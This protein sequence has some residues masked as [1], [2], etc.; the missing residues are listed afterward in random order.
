MIP[1]LEFQQR[2]LTGPVMKVDEF[3]LAL[4]KT[5]RR[6]VPKYGIKYNPEELVVD[7]Q[8][9]DAVFQAGVEMLVD[10]GLYNLDTQRVIKFTHEELEEI[11][12]EYRANPARRT[13]G[14]GKDEFTIEC[15]TGEDSR[16]PVLGS[17]ATGVVQEEWHIAYVQ[18]LAQEEMVQG[19]GITGGI[20]SVGGIVPKVG[21]IT[22]M[23]CGLWEQEA[24][25]EALKRAGR[26]D[27]HLGVLHTV[28]SVGGTL[29]CLS[30]GVRGPHNVQVSVHIMPELK[31][32]WTRLILA[33]VCESK[34]I[35]P[36][37]NA[38][39]LLGGL[40]GGPAG[41][42]VGLVANLLGQ[43]AYAHGL[44]GGIFPSD[45]EGNFSDR[46]CL[47]AHS[48][49][50]RAAG[51]NLRLPIGGSCASNFNVA[52]KEV[53]ILEAAAKAIVM[54]ASGMAYCWGGGR[55]VLEARIIGDIL[56]GAAGMSRTKANELVKAILRELEEQN[57]GPLQKRYFPDLYDITTLRPKAEFVDT[58]SRAVEKL[59]RLG[60]PLSGRLVLS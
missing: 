22:E 3:D 52:G 23:H 7:D 58:C 2:S 48:A 57:E 15:R 43:L 30:S 14:R 35:E 31:L 13:F 26:P 36:W 8:I 9:A 6:L 45:M 39:A 56:N 27:M 24:L 4:V 55:N 18:S 17:L 5:V 50:A 49:A 11:A 42:A 51:R 10:T 34:G 41:T 12:A 44:F 28:T 29:A 1:L 53:T 46:G 40:C 54:T 60:V 21:T 59:A 19:F 20:A 47:W 32:D 25:R 38:M 37:T 16:P 33:Y